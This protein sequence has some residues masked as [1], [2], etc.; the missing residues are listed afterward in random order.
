MLEEIAC[1]VKEC[2]GAFVQ[3]LNREFE[4]AQN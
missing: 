1:K 2:S 3:G 4:K